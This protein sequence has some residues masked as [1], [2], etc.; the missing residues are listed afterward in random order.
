M[1]HN[2]VLLCLWILHF[3]N[4]RAK[5][6]E[7]CTDLRG[8]VISHGLHYVPGPDICTLCV[9]D[10]GLPK[11]CKSVM[12][13]PP[14]DCKS[15]RMGDTC[16][17]FICLDDIMK[18]V[19]STAANI[20]V[21]D[22]RAR[23]CTDLRGRVISHGLHYVPGP[24]ICKICVCD[25]GMPKVCKSALCSPPKDCK[26]FRMGDTCCEFI[27]LDD[28]VKPIDSTEANIRVAD[29]RAQGCTDLRGHVISHGLHYVPGPDICT[30]CV[31]DSGRPKLCY[32]DLCTLPKDCKT[33]RMGD[34]CCE[35]ICLD[36]IV[37]SVD[38]T[39]ANIR[40]AAGGAA[41]VN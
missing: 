1:L 15:F 27:C 4:V 14:K 6:W 33:F 2:I 32:S 35:F 13:S 30:K 11:V 28:I 34:T 19:D 38:S 16:C 23:G 40:V 25:N 21:T 12:C 20:S 5:T 26:S 22:T 29:A 31:C 18:P 37:K 3:H 41:S 39:E 7:G 8:R 36:D 24:D 10:S 17:E 9:C